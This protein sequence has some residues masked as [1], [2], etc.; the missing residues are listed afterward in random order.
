MVE[1]AEGK[2]FAEKVWNEM[3]QVMEITESK[4]RSILAAS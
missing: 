4:V 2:K 3:V 1:T